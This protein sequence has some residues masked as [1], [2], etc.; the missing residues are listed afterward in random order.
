MHRLGDGGVFRRFGDGDVKSRIDFL[1]ARGSGELAH[2][3]IDR[4]QLGKLLVRDALRRQGTSF[5][6]QDEP[7]LQQFKGPDALV[8]QGDA[9]RVALLRN[10]NA[11]PGAHI[12]QAGHLQGDHRFAN[13][14]AGN[15]EHLGKVPLGGQLL[16]RLHLAIG[17]Q[18]RNASR[19]AHIQPLL[20]FNGRQLHFGPPTR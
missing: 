11:G 19:H 8:V 2:L 14:R 9:L 13:G 18:V 3:F 17:H 20:A 12:D 15:L 5:G 16:P 10:V 1:Y 6:F 7:Q 4:L